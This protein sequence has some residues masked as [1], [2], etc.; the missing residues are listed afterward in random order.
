MHKTYFSVFM[1]FE[2]FNFFEKR[3]MLNLKPTLTWRWEKKKKKEY[4]VLF[5]IHN[6]KF[7]IVPIS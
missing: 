1:Y 2:V 3:S 4:Y 6:V 7:V 5:I